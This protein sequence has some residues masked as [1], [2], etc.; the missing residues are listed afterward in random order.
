MLP[1]FE[2]GHFIRV[3]TERMMDY[4]YGENGARNIYSNYNQMRAYML[5]ALQINQKNYALSTFPWSNRQ[6][7]E[8]SGKLLAVFVSEFTRVLFCSSALLAHDYKIV[9]TVVCLQRDNC[10]CNT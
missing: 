5:N 1:T 10:F 2:K 3:C 9:T 8:E 6:N 4:Q 7:I